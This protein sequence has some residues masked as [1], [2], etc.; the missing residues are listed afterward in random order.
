MQSPSLP[1]TEQQVIDGFHSFL[2]TALAQARAERLL[3][4]DTLASA[5]A[6]LMI[7]GMLLLQFW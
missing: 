2:Q 3:D 4:A 6:D 1:L 7:S 5:E